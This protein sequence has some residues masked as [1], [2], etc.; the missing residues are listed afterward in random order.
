M[1]LNYI[2]GSFKPHLGPAARSLS[3]PERQ[4]LAEQERW[5]QSEGGYG[6]IQ[7]TKPQT[8]AYDLH[9]SPAGLAAWV[10]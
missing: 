9:D 1:H 4:F 7:G 10:V 6:H 2:P 5:S 8:L 3:E